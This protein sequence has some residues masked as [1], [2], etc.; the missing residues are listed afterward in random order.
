MRT[1]CLRCEQAGTKTMLVHTLRG[2]CCPI[3]EADFLAA[4]EANARA[5]LNLPRPV[6]L[7]RGV[8]TRP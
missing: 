8:S 5:T 4:L 7:G 2:N 1:T 6:L 3:H